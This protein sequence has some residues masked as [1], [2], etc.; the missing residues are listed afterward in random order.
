MVFVHTVDPQSDGTVEGRLGAHLGLPPDLPAS[1]GAAPE[2]RPRV[3]N[4][5]LAK[6]FDFG[7]TRQLLRENV[8]DLPVTTGA[9]A[10]VAYSLTARLLMSGEMA[11]VLQLYRR[12]DL[13]LTSTLMVC[14]RQ[15]VTEA[16]RLC[17]SHLRKLGVPEYDTRASRQ[18]RV[19]PP[20]IQ[21]A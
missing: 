10:N 17:G 8:D 7:G 9:P 4:L 14:D 21:A 3:S 20:A 16:S 13:V 18:P 11:I 6:T 2:D 12:H 5:S 19:T 15:K 1:E